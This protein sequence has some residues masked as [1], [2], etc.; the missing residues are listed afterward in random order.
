[1]S[2]NFSL[3]IGILFAAKCRYQIV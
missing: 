1:M 3:R 2:S